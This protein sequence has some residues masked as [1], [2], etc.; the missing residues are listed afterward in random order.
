M[1]KFTL[2]TLAEFDGTNG[3][4]AYIAVK[5]KVYDVTKYFAHGS[6]HGAK[7]GVD[8]T[9]QMTGGA[10]P[11]GDAVLANLEPVGILVDEK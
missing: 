6:H 1:K 9:E 8:M 10:H 4:P 11:H 5:G 7:A 2:K 3:K